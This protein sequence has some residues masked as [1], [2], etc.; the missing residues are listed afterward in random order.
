M[1]WGIR[2]AEET[3]NAPDKE[4]KN[5]LKDMLEDDFGAESDSNNIYFYSEVSRGSILSLN[6]EIVHMNK[7]LAGLQ[8]K[9]TGITVPD[10][11]LHINSGGGSLIDCFAG[12]DYIRRSKIPVHSVVEGMAASAATILSC[13]SHKRS[14]TKNSFMLI[15]QLSA[16][17]WGKYEEMK[18][19]MQNCD[20]LMERIKDIYG[21]HTKIPAGVLKDLL[22]RDLLLDANTCKKYGLVDAIID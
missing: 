17:V 4:S 20:L 14:I 18:D 12:V 11:V 7:D 9:Y 15:H 16:G 1:R 6:K 10:I 19:S 2:N 3:K 22:K 8:S 21:K 13:V 5:S